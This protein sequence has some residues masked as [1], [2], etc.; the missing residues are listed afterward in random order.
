[1]SALRSLEHA[2]RNLFKH[3]GGKTA[4]LCREMALG[5]ARVKLNVIGN[6]WVNPPLVP[7]RAKTFQKYKYKIS[8]QLVVIVICD[9][10]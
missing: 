4:D 2:G 10:T 7:H 3:M 5:L 6:M 8:S 9:Q 1:M